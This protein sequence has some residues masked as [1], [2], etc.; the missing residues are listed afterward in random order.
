LQDSQSF[1]DLAGFFPLFEVDDKAESGSGCER[2]ILLGYAQALARLS[3]QLTDLL[4]RVSQGSHLQFPY[5][6]ITHSGRPNQAKHYR[7]GISMNRLALSELNIP[8]R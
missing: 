6:N 7:T 5:G 3:D 8:V 2:Q 1:A 4:Y